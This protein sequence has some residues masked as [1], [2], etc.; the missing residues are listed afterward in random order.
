MRN[1]SGEAT[2]IAHLQRSA[3]FHGSPRHLNWSHLM[4]EKGIIWGPNSNK[5]ARL[6]SHIRRSGIRVLASEEQSCWERRQTKIP[7]RSIWTMVSLFAREMK[8]LS[9]AANVVSQ[10]LLEDI[11]NVFGRYFTDSLRVGTYE[12]R[13]NAPMRTDGKHYLSTLWSS[14]DVSPSHDPP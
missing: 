4:A 7:D 13:I 5:H 11:G 2:P 8:Q 14:R 1:E 3:S 10:E 9:L 6:S 12:V